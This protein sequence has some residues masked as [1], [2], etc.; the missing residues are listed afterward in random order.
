MATQQMRRY[1]PTLQVPDFFALSDIPP[2]AYTYVRSSRAWQYCMVFLR[3]SVV[4]LALL[5][6]PTWDAWLFLLALYL[7]DLFC[8]RRVRPRRMLLPEPS[9]NKLFLRMAADAEGRKLLHDGE[10]IHQALCTVVRIQSRTDETLLEVSALFTISKALMSMRGF[11]HRQHRRFRVMGVVNSQQN[12]VLAGL[13]ARLC[14]EA[15]LLS[16]AQARYLKQRVQFHD[17]QLRQVR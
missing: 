9:V 3:L 16:E 10:I 13:V 15:E 12:I 14:L 11:A 1:A 6:P 2:S 8:A 5:V 4:F 7:M 17:G